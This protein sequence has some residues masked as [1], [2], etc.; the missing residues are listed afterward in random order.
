MKANWVANGLGGQSMYLFYLACHRRIPATLSITGDTGGENDR[1]C[2][3][4][5]DFGCE[6]G[7]YCGL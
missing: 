5:A 3:N 1:V 2:S 6:D 7:A 4:V